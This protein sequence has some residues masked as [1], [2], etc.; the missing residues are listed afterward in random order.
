MRVLWRETSF[1]RHLSTKKF[2]KVLY[3]VFL[4]LVQLWRARKLPLYANI[5]GKRNY[6]LDESLTANLSTLPFTV[7][8]TSQDSQV[9]NGVQDAW[10]ARNTRNVVYLSWKRATFRPMR[11]R[12]DATWWIVGSWIPKRRANH[13]QSTHRDNRNAANSAFPT[14]VRT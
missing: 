9:L 13:D 1:W 7:S 11:R 14:L 5:V 3:H 10:H 8:V 2:W 4:S 12:C 6:C